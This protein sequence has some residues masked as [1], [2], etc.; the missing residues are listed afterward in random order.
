MNKK[1][2]QI[3]STTK[4]GAN[5]KHNEFITLKRKKLQ[6]FF[7]W[8]LIILA[9]A[10]G[11]VYAI[12]KLTI[13][14]TT[15]ILTH[16]IAEKN[17]KLEPE[18]VAKRDSAIS[19]VYKRKYRDNYCEQYALIA[20]YSGYYPV[21]Y[22]GLRI[23]NDSIY[24]LQYEVWKYGK[25]INGEFARYPNGVFYTDGKKILTTE[26]LEYIIQFT[27]TETECLA[28]EK[29]KIYNYPLLLECQKR[30]RKLIRP[31]GNKIDN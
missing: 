16:R 15:V 24:L 13:L 3:L 11:F 18:R 7:V 20:A 9:I 10:I 31:P 29:R 12:S 17:P 26:N 27:G 8:I 2:V 25:T 23:S 14:D 30:I 28:E 5:L 22:R 21:L 6:R 1:K 4:Q 19:R